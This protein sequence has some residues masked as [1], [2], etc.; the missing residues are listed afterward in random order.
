MAFDFLGQIFGRKD[1]EKA[2]K[3]A[4]DKPEKKQMEAS[5]IL[6]WVSAQ[7][8]KEIESDK[9]KFSGMA[10]NLLQLI[11]DLRKNVESIRHKSF[12]EGDRTYAAVNMIK[13]TWAKKA[14]MSFTSYNREIEPE[15]VSKEKIDFTIFRNLYHN[16]VRL[17]N[18]IT[19]IPRQKI[20]LSRYFEKE[21]RRMSEILKSISEIM[22]SMELAVNGKSSLKSAE[23]AGM[24]AGQLG[25]LLNEAERIEKDIEKLRSDIKIKTDEIE[26]FADRVSLIDKK[27]DWKLLEELDGKIKD[28]MA[29]CEE[30][31]KEAS[32]KLGS[33]KRVFKLYAHDAE[34]GKEERRLFEN[35]SHSPLK[36][37]LSTDPRAVQNILNRL[38]QDIRNGKFKLSEKDAGKTHELAGIVKSGWISGKRSEYDEIQTENEEARRKKE[39]INVMVEKRE[40]ERALEKIR[41]DIEI[42]RR[43]DAELDKKMKERENE[44]KNKKNEISDFIKKELGLEIEVD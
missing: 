24:M 32:E 29:G 11:T 38:D 23:K 42:L 7:H 37:F 36:T 40:S 4:H 17:M 20:V 5:E 18:N 9:N 19:M 12:E 25:L 15:K 21:S 35:L 22:G 43:Q 41:T 26:I 44:V 28:S 3:E 31:E 39:G 1:S 16:T 8:A 13:D 10:G 30:I 14:L 33:M 2:E 27:P 6:E 34:L